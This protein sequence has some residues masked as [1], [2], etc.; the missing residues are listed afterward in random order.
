MKIIVL[1]A[2]QGTRLRP[3]TDNIPKCM[4]PL[5]GKPLIDYQLDLFKFKSIK[6]ITIVGGYLIE[7]LKSKNVNLI[8]NKAYETTN[9]VHSLFCAEKELNDD[10][11][12]SYG[13]IVYTDKVLQKLIDSNENISVV[14]DKN[15]KEYW[16][17][18]MDDPLSDAETLKIKDGKII[19]IGKKPNHYGDIEGQ[20]IGLIKFS[21]EIIKEIIN[22][23]NGLD[24]TIKYDG[25]DFNNMYMTS[26][27]SLLGEK[28]SP[29]K[30]IFIN[31]GWM[32]VDCPEDLEHFNFLNHGK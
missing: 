21:K 17:A 12:I 8:T 28:I 20:Y 11:I 9:M 27:L 15:W 19:E 3:L 18:R 10:V 2:G 6:D 1:A 25:K 32:E 24:K 4:V 26:F 7:K 5:K 22:F 30:P 14:V 13:D 16:K 31:N 29:L 23:Y